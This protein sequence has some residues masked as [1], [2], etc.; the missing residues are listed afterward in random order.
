MAARG[1][2]RRPAAAAVAAFGLA[3]LLLLLAPTPSRAVEAGTIFEMHFQTKCIYQ[4]LEEGEL[5]TIDWWA[6]RKADEQ[7]Q[8]MMSVVVSDPDGKEI[9]TERST[10]QS[11][12]IIHAVEDGDYSICFTAPDKETAQKTYV[13]VDWKLG[14]MARDWE[15][16]AK[17]E[18]LDHLQVELR[19]Y[20]EVVKDIHKEMRHIRDK[21]DKLKISRVAA[22][23]RVALFTMLTIVVCI[24]TT[25][26]QYFYLKRFFKSKKL[27]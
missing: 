15:A 21:E 7:P 23:S 2:P 26:F 9:E 19:K 12:I 11:E 13:S 17:K 4:D 10:A 14:A 3:A 18:H 27:L 5:M 6:W 25:T 22:E 24:S 16:I 20:E 1:D 8:K